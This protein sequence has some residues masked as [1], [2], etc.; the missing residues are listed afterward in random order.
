MIDHYRPKIHNETSEY[1]QQNRRGYRVSIMLHNGLSL[2][3]TGLIEHVT[4]NRQGL[5]SEAVMI[6]QIS[7][8]QIPLHPETRHTGIR[9]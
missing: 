4:K 1:L 6:N 2:P 8:L 5:L 3:G 7:F 9:Y